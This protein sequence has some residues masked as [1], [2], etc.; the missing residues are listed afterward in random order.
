MTCTV[1]KTAAHDY[2]LGLLTSS[3]V[4]RLDAHVERCEECAEFMRICRELSCREFVEFLNDYVGE[5]LDP[6]RRA[7]FDRHLAICPDCT[8]YLDS[9]RK[10]ARLSF[11]SLATDVVPDEPIP[12]ALL[13][14]I[15][16]ARP[17]S[18]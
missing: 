5:E 10:T 4:A 18:G 12:E 14:A 1:L 7:V 11:T 17:P 9:Y 15:L 6:E 3:E 8:A 2:F 16:A 13:R